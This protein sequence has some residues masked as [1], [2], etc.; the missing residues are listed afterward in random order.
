MAQRLDLRRIPNGWAVYL[1]E[2]QALFG[3]AWIPLP[4]TEQA[5]EA[6]V[7]THCNLFQNKGRAK[8]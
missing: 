7:R 8:A 3:T 5:S 1:P 4:F 6:Y 2:E